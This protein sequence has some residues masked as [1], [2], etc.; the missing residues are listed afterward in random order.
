L[1]VGAFGV[2]AR[3]VNRHLWLAGMVPLHWF[4]LAL[5]IGG[6]FLLLLGSPWS[7]FYPAR[8]AEVPR[9]SFWQL[10]WLALRAAVTATLLG[11]MIWIGVF[12]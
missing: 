11:A 10:G 8:L 5:M 12:R 2:S 1:G 9:M 7:P 3:G 4:Y 6:A